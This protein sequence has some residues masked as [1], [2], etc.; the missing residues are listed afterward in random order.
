MTSRDE[1]DARQHFRERYAVAANDLT[2]QIEAS[3]IGAVW[4]AN[5][6]TTSLLDGVNA[7]AHHLI[8]L[9]A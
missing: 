5:G 9:V 4:G 2:A 3:V 7:G 6:Y 1:R 8:S